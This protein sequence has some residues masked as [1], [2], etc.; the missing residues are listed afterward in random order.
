MEE[1]KKLYF[2]TILLIIFAIIILLGGIYIYRISNKQNEVIKPNETNEIQTLFE[3]FLK[4][5]A[6]AYKGD[7]LELLNIGYDKNKDVDYEDNIITNVKYNDYKNAMLNYVTEE[8]FEREYTSNIG[9]TKSED[10]FV[11]K[12]NN[13]DYE[14][15]YKVTGIIEKGDNSYIASITETNENDVT[16]K[17][18]REFTVKKQNE[19][20]VIDSFSGSK[21]NSYDN[22]DTK[23]PS[24][25]DVTKI[26]KRFLDMDSMAHVDGIL[27]YLNI[28]Y[29]ESKDSFDETT[30]MVTTNVKYDDYKSV[31]LNYVSE[32]FFEKEY[33]KNIGI[34]KNK[35][36]ML[37]KSQG[38]GDYPD[39]E[40]LKVS[41]TK[42]LS[43]EAEIK[44]SYSYNDE[45]SNETYKFTL[46]EY[47]GKLVI[48]TFSERQ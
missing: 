3:S 47:N 19:K 23:D 43:Y 30:E 16:Y 28:G 38:G 1:K 5:D 36:G 35:N 18:T 4:I 39:I 42:D 26:F 41:K 44:T 34:S 27:G 10:G 46:K 12:P 22:V 37:I 48:D 21:T 13:R 15:T 24:I 20:L 40:I 8:F 31:M 17:G 2:Q 14:I 45:T 9:F 25:E 32:S 29:D 33:T 6:S 7:I 11:I